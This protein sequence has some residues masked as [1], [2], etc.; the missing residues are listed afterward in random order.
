VNAWGRIVNDLLAP[1]SDRSAKETKE[2]SSHA[3]TGTS[4]SPSLSPSEQA[5]TA[6][7]TPRALSVATPP[8]PPLCPSSLLSLANYQLRDGF[9]NRRQMASCSS[10]VGPKIGFAPTTAAQPLILTPCFAGLVPQAPLFPLA[11]REWRGSPAPE[12]TARS[13]SSSAS[14]FEPQPQQSTARRTPMNEGLE[15]EAPVWPG[16]EMFLAL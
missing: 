1:A 2:E 7:P 10:S 6:R 9:I 16:I 13:F 8:P 3:T 11:S 12:L 15:A 14:H 5:N 4:S